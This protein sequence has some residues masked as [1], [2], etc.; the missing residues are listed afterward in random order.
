M[1]WYYALNDQQKG[2]VE[3]AELDRLAQQGSI[4]ANTFVWREGMAQWQPY[5]TISLGSAP[6]VIASGMN[7][8]MCADCTQTFAP[9]ELIQIGG[10][11]ICGKCKPLA[12]QRLREGIAKTDL[13]AEEIRKLHLSHEASIKSVGTLYLLGGTFMALGAVGL[14]F[15]VLLDSSS[16]GAPKAISLT[17]F[18]IFLPLAV[19][20]FW[21]SSG[22]KNLNPR[23]RTVAGILAGIG[24]IGFPFGTLING[25][26]LYLLFSAKG[27]MVFSDEYK[28]VIEATPHIKYRT[29]LLVWIFLGI[30]LLL[31]LI[32]IGMAVFGG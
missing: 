12:L 10:K 17:Q 7:L 8:T 24:L 21:L 20:M 16:R 30:I 25:Y 6:P 4:T 28:S 26:I 2:P 27:K 23:A 5:G 9:D 3:Q 32:G 13:N 31:I 19:L 1:N 29:S 18:I 14:L 15:T 22:L 11:F